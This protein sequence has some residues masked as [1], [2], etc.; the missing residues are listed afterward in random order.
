MKKRGQI[1]VF[2]ILGIT[3]LLL[4]VAFLSLKSF[5]T[6]QHAKVEEEKTQQTILSGESIKAYVQSCIERTTKD[7]ILENS[8]SGG[9]FI[10]PKKS[11]KDL[12]YNVP[13]YFQNE[14]DLSPPDELIANEIVKYIDEKLDQCLNDFKPFKEQGYEI[15]I[16]EKPESEA[17]F[18]PKKITVKTSFPMTIT[19]GEST[20]QISNFMIS[21]PAAEF[22]QNILTAREI[23][24]NQENKEICISCFSNLALENDL[25]V[26]ILPMAENT[27]IIELMD[28]NY[29]INEQNYRLRF[30]IQYNET[31]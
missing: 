20:K 30:A 13:Y 22:Y 10:L 21:I 23:I 17:I 18:S 9:Y 5:I 31:E 3:L 12:F 8:F 2:I 27:F 6:A 26:N 28:N 7:A 29:L 25:F 4:V 19:I 24:K 1:T 16:K 14:Q 11:T 15:V